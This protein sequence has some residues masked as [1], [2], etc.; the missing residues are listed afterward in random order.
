M[1]WMANNHSLLGYDMAFRK[2]L[3]RIQEAN[4][5]KADDS[6]VESLIKGVVDD[7]R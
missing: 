2:S 5:R 6:E 1:E 3:A 7:I 4:K